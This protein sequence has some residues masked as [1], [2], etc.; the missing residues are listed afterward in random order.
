MVELN[1]KKASVCVCIQWLGDL[2]RI[3][4]KN[5]FE[6]R[7]YLMAAAL[8]VCVELN[9]LCQWSSGDMLTSQT[10]VGVVNED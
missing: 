5:N 8:C 4:T 2:C 6:T 1:R 10:L 3:K 7:Q 9:S